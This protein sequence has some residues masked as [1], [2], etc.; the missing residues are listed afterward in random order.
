MAPLKIKQTA[1]HILYLRGE[2][3]LDSNCLVTF[4]KIKHGSEVDTVS[5]ISYVRED[6]LPVVN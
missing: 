5:E 6:S 3:T 2:D 1:V 4:K